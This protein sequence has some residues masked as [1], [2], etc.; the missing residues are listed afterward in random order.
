VTCRIYYQKPLCAASRLKINTDPRSS[1]QFYVTK[2]N[3]CDEWVNTYNPI[4]L[5]AWQANMD[6]QMV[7]SEYGAAMYV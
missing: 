7:G 3:D 2:I 4:L 5:F 1:A 6:N